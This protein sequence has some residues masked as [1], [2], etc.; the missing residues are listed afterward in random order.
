MQCAAV[1]SAVV[2][3]KPKQEASCPNHPSPEAQPQ[4]LCKDVE[5]ATEKFQLDHAF[6]PV[7]D[8]IQISLVEEPV[9]IH[10]A[11]DI[12]DFPPPGTF[13]ILRL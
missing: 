10:R 5:V 3:E 13:S 7:P 1:C 9:L 2:C 12:P 6:I 11:L 8:L 4:K